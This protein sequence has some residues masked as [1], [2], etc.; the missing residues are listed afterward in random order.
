M[1]YSIEYK[2][3][4]EK[5]YWQVKVFG[6]I[7]IF[8]SQEFKSNLVELLNECVADLRIDCSEL[9]YMDS[10]ALGSLVGALKNVK[11]LNREL[12]LHNV[13]PNLKKLFKITNLDKAFLIEGDD[14][15]RS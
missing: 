3:V 14:N 1:D 4:E 7:D 10:T 6:E 15:E 5:K 9:N 13:K 11:A 2:Y 8:S 12:Y